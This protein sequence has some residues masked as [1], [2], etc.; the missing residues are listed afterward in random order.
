MATVKASPGKE[1]RDVSAGLDSK[2]V[3]EVAVAVLQGNF[4]LIFELIPIFFPIYTF[5]LFVLSLF[6]I[7]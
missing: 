4:L 1:G 7:R 2:E 6:F 5:K 3:K